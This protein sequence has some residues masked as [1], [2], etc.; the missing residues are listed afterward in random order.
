MKLH[1]KVKLKK[2]STHQELKN[3][4]GFF[5]WS[6]FKEKDIISSGD[7]SKAQLLSD[8]IEM[9]GEFYQKKVY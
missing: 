7:S 5:K 6:L 4:E 1:S 2:K 8:E 9:L 3:Y